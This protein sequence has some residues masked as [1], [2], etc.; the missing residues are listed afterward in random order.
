[1][2]GYLAFK[3]NPLRIIKL[4][5]QVDR[6]EIKEYEINFVVVNVQSKNLLLGL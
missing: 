6:N 2:Y 4:L 5:C 3:I 1:M